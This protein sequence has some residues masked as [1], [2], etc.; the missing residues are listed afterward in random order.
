[1]GTRHGPGYFSSDGSGR[2]D[3]ESPSGTLYAARSV[4]TAAMERIAGPVEQ[5]DGDGRARTIDG[6]YLAG[7]IEEHDAENVLIWELTAERPVAMANLT[8]RGASAFGVTMEL[9]GGGGPDMYAVA[10]EWA[11]AF[12]AE[13]LGGIEYTSRFTSS[14]SPVDNAVAVFDAAGQ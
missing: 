2:F 5:R 13:S 11:A 8:D 9:S 12:A 14:T 6:P 3:L 1:T 7:G 10:Q 4:H